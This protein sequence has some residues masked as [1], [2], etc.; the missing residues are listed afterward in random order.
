MYVGMFSIFHN[1]L[2]RIHILYR[3]KLIMA[4]FVTE[5]IKF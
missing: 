5:F 3:I 4:E 1:Y 2:K